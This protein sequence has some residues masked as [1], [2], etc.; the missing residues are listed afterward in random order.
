VPSRAGR[1]R[2]RLDGGSVGAHGVCPSIDATGWRTETATAW[3]DGPGG[4]QAVV[5]A[6][7]GGPE[8]AG[9]PGVAAS[10]GG[11]TPCAPTLPPAGA[12]TKRG[13]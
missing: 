8:G 9:R 7:F 3:N 10:I 2:P 13:L 5:A 12:R 4:N 6:T 1:P 11:H